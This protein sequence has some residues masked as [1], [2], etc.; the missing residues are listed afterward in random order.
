MVA[1]IRYRTTGAFYGVYIW[2]EGW[3]ATIVDHGYLFDGNNGLLHNVP[4][5]PLYPLLCK[6]LKML[7]PALHTSLAMLVISNIFAYLTIRLLFVLSKEMFNFRIA[8]FTVLLFLSLPFSFFIFLGFTES[9][10][11]TLVLTFFYFYSV[12]NERFLP[13]ILIALASLTRLY[14]ILLF[15]VYLVDLF[16]QKDR[17]L[18][19][20]EL[21]LA[22]I[23]TLGISLFCIYHHYTFGHPYLFIANQIAW[24]HQSTIGLLNLLKFKEIAIKA[25]QFDMTN[26][27]SIAA[28]YFVSSLFLSITIYKTLPRSFFSYYIVILSFLFYILSPVANSIG[29]YML[30]LFPVIITVP[31]VLLKNPKEERF[32]LSDVRFVIFCFFLF[33]INLNLLQLCFERVHFVG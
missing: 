13:L 4:F 12:K 5:F 20:K 9:L 25:L 17:G 6:A 27:Q 24:G 23:A 21:F 26:P 30:C 8:V 29:R 11:F 32:E 1:A 3:Y 14:G 31:L 33:T 28:I 16:Y 15:V 22:P 7:L 18:F 19:R 10:F 2:D